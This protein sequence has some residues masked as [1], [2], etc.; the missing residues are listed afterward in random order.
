[1]LKNTFKPALF[2][3]LFR[4]SINFVKVNTTKINET[5]LIAKVMRENVKISKT[6]K[7]GNCMA[8]PVF[9]L[10]CMEVGL[11]DVVIRS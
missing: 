3:L 2:I 11:S 10:R 6:E 1:M 8:V 9:L 7:K 4:N 5:T